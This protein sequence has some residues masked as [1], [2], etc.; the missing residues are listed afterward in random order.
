MR[1]FI[2]DGA[3]PRN[4]EA[5]CQRRA[6]LDSHRV[7]GLNRKGEKRRVKIIVTM[8]YNLQT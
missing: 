4:R 5:I 7:A 2:G 3:H 8:K 6:N 1:N